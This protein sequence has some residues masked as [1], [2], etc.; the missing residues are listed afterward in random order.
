MNHHA[1][2]TG[3]AEVWNASKPV[4]NKVVSIDNPDGTAAA[5]LIGGGG[6]GGG[7]G[8]G[9]DGG[10]GDGGDGGGGGGGDGGGGDGGDADTE[11]GGGASGGSDSAGA[12]GVG[13]GC[14]A[15]G[16]AGGGGDN[17][18]DDDPEKGKHN[19]VDPSSF[20]GS[21]QNVTDDQAGEAAVLSACSQQ[22]VP[23]AWGGECAGKGFDCSGLTKWAWEQQGVNLPH[24]AQQQFDDTAHVQHI[25]IRG[26]NGQPDFSKL[27]PGDLL[28]YKDGNGH[29]GH[30]TMFVGAPEGKPLM[31]E[32]PQQGQNVS[33]T[34][35]RT[36]GLNMEAGRPHK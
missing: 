11:G 13:G 4:H 5:N 21:W 27:K 23:Y 25:N 1:G 15:D 30:V 26:E 34:A 18:D 16:G 7:G 24:E 8:D 32:A 17:D 31:I 6:G 20:A 9:G 33:V 19:Q 10:G 2:P 22:N 12:A 35:V 3:F 29:I 28:F 36:S 14:A